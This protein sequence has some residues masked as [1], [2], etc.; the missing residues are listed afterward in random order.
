MKGRSSIHI[1]TSGWHYSH[2]KGPFYP[3]YL[4]E[5]SMLEFYAGRFGTV[6]I[7]NS[8][9]RMPMKDTLAHWRD[10]VPDDFIFAVKASR[11]ITH[12]K[13]LRNVGEPLS[14]FLDLIG[15]L[16]RKLGPVLFQLPPRWHLNTERLLS[17]LDLLPKDYRFAFEFRD[18][19]WFSP[20]VYAALSD[21]GVSFCIY[22]LGGVLSPKEVTSDIAYIRLHG[23]AGP[24]RGEY[25]TPVLEGW[26]GAFATWVGQGKEI[27]CFFDN[28]EAGHA[29]HDALRLFTMVQKRQLHKN[30]K[31][32]DMLKTSHSR[33]S[34]RNRQGKVRGPA[35]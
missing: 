27:Y 29:P 12:M 26:A 25:E 24:Y 28:D 10:S 23:P 13:K 8:F 18:P 11:Y 30:P 9:Y 33:L 15:I 14:R 17:F 22:D 20:E 3:P 34:F 1:G 2:W 35:L 5:D 21:S 19:S 16:G 31:K 7:N 4:A 32:K 6:E